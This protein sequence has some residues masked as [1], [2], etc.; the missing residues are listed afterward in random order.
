MFLSGRRVSGNGLILA[1]IQQP[2]KRL[3]VF[4]ELPA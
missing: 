1:N 2:S 3:V 4:C